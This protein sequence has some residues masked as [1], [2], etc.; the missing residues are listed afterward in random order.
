MNRLRE[1]STRWTRSSPRTRATTGDASGVARRRSSRNRAAA[2]AVL[3][4]EVREVRRHHGIAPD[5]AEALGAPVDLAAARADDAA[6]AG[7][8]V[9]LGRAA[10]D[11]AR[12]RKLD[13]G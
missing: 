6:L 2:K 3:L 8:L 1:S 12:P 11:L 9:R 7:Q 5:R 13:V 4:A 10:L